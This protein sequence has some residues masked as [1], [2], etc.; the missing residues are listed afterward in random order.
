MTDK[1][2]VALDKLAAATAQVVAAQDATGVS[3]AE[4]I[5]S[6]LR[7]HVYRFPMDDAAV[8]D[9]VRILASAAWNQE[10]NDDSGPVVVVGEKILAFIR[11]NR[12]EVGHVL[13]EKPWRFSFM[14]SLAPDEARVVNV[15]LSVLLD[16]GVLILNEQHQEPALT[17]V[18][19]KLVY[20]VR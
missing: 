4:R 10:Q 20:G 9:L 13:P 2:E 12:L 6:Q 14:P 1:F 15:A 16:R 11:E 8:Q 5:A 3:L 18:G 17:E 19:F 7:E